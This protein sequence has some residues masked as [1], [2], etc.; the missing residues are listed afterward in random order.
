MT[1][2]EVSDIAEGAAERAIQKMPLT[3]GMDTVDA[4][5]V[6][7]LQADFRHLRQWRESIDTV[8]KQSLKAAIGVVVPGV[9]GWIVVALHK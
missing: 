9:I 7:N 8:K 1:P 2:Q 6:L 5:A 4:D 3:I